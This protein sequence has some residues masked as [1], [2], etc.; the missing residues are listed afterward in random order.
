MVG[1]LLALLRAERP[2]LIA[3]IV[4]VRPAF[5]RAVA[6]IAICA[7]QWIAGASTGWFTVPVRPLLE[8]LIV[9]YLIASLIHV[10][11]G[12]MYRVLNLPAIAW[13]GVLSYSLYVWQQLF[14]YPE[15]GDGYAAFA[16]QTLPL[17]LWLLT[18]AAIL[19]YYLIERPFLLLKDRW[20]SK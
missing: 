19:S 2:T 4:E 17:A 20:S 9:A 13:I 6:L 10:R 12:I 5:G 1:C 15:G 7:V 16:F 3:A 14:L 8:A 11:S 18:I